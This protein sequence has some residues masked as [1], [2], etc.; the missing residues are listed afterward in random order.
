[1]YCAFQ[2]YFFNLDFVEYGKLRDGPAF[3][4]LGSNGLL[5]AVGYNTRKT[6]EIGAIGR[7]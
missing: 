2:M 6:G 1:M 4:T 3:T 7:T 5:V